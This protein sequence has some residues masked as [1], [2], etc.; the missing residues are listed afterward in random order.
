MGEI[1]L[2][3]YF[4]ESTRVFVFT[5]VLEAYRCKSLELDIEA[6][7]SSS[8]LGGGEWNMNTALRRVS[9]FTSHFVEGATSLSQYDIQTGHDHRLKKSDVNLR[10]CPG[11]CHFLGA[12]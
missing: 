12:R 6:F 7:Y 10:I 1:Q 5:S 3:A 4:V 8:R 2:L 11:S 9:I